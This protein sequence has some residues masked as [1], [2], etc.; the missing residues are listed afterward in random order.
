M[1]RLSSG[2]S[3]AEDGTPV[4]WNIFAEIETEEDADELAR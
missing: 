4:A 2:G 3:A 1:I